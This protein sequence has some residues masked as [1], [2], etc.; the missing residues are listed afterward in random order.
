MRLGLRITVLASIVVLLVSAS[1]ADDSALGAVGGTLQPMVEHPSIR[2][3][4]EA[5]NI[6]VGPEKIDVTCKFVFRNEGKAVDVKMG[7]PEEHGGD[8]SG[9]AYFRARVDGKSVKVTH[10]KT[11]HEES[12]DYRDWY[13]KTV[14]FGRGRTRVVEDFYGGRPSGDSSGSTYVV[15]VLETG[16]SWKGPIGR[17]VIT[18]DLSAVRDFQTFIPSPA[19]YR[20]RGNHITWE[21]RDFEPKDNI[22]LDYTWNYTWF[23]V[24]GTSMSD[25]LLCNRSWPPEMRIS[26]PRVVNGLLMVPFMKF[27]ELL[28]GSRCEHSKSKDEVLIIYRDKTLRLKAGSRTAYLNGK[29]IQ[30][31]RSP[32]VEGY[33][34][35]IPF[36]SV[37]QA[38][39]F[40]VTR[41]HVHGRTSIASPKPPKGNHS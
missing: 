25:S 24:D 22:K 27:E 23:I 33:H 34:L 10:T 29:S 12:D 26:V 32:R 18:M 5:V 21:W 1:H 37:G 30:L 15:Y 16:R 11:K 9:F 20:K 17:A 2:M 6:Q 35:A 7:F 19:G 14:H 31:P 39:G 40:K 28:P 8:S 38:L 13:V 41:D 36:V 4:S 3:V